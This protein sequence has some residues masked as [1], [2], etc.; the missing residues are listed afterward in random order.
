MVSDRMKSAYDTIASQYA[1]RYQVMPSVLADLCQTLLNRLPPAPSI[2]DAGCG[3]GRDM[4]WFEAHGCNVTGIDLS[5]GMLERARQ[6]LSGPLLEM[7]LTAIDLPIGSFDGIWCN[8]ALLHI[9]KKTAPDVLRQFSTVLKPGGTLVL[10][11]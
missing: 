10:G 1:E 6:I 3:A 4:V 5:P 2:L 11:V 7:D 9:P 8:A